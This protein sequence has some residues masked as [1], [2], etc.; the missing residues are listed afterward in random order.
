MDPDGRNQKHFARGLRNAVGL[1]WVRERLY[2]TNMGS[3]HL[4]DHKPADTMYA[5]GQGMNYGWPY[6]YQSGAA[7]LE[8]IKFNPGGKKLNC[9]EV[10]LA[11]AAF[12]A[13]SSPLGFEFFDSLDMGPVPKSGYGG[14][15]RDSFLVALH[16]S[17]K[18]SL[19]RGYRVV[20]VRA[21]RKSDDCPE[22][23]INGFLAAGKINGR[24]VDILSFGVDGFLLT[25]DAAGVVYY[26][27]EK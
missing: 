16:G 17:T 3:D 26:V 21:D 24:P 14:P 13:H 23:F 15:L 25:D 19:N 22:D 9:R 27:H 1:R 6:C 20:R 18:K 2:A 11:F 12:D 4:G 8:D 5:L 7:R 10:P